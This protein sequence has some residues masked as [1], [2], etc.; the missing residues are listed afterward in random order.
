MRILRGWI[1]NRGWVIDA[2]SGASGSPVIVVPSEEYYAHMQMTD[3][4]AN[5]PVA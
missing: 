5:M 3:I 1:E 2:S 4:H